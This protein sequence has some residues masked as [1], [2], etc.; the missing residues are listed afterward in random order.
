LLKALQM[1]RVSLLLADDVGLGKTVEAGLI[2]TE[3]LIRRRVR[4]VLILTPA[5]LSQQWQR[6]MQTKFALNFDLID[7]AETHALQRR[8]GLDANPWRTYPRII[9]SYYYLRQPDI[10]QQFLATSGTPDQASGGPRA[11]LPWD[12]LIVD[13]AHNLLP[14]PFGDDN[15]FVLEVVKAWTDPA[16]KQPKT[17]HHHGY[18]KFAVDGEMIKLKSRMP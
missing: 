10:L 4:R 9:A 16:Q 17:I 2:L 8:V 1:P 7:R 13:E 12:L 15:L 5:S 3:L 11:Q 14:S 6:E 18:G